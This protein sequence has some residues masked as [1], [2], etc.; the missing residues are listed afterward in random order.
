MI[1]MGAFWMGCLI[2]PFVLSFAFFSYSR[3]M[4]DILQKFWL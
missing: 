4:C 1:V 3:K 2:L